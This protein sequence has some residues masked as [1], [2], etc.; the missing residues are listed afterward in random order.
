MCVRAVT[1]SGRTTL[2]FSLLLASISAGASSFTYDF[3]S[4]TASQPLVGQDGWAEIAGLASPTLGAGLGVNPSRVSA[5][6]GSAGGNFAGATRTLGATFTYSP[7]DTAV[8]WEFDGLVSSAENSEVI[9]VG[10][11]G[12]RGSFGQR[13]STTVLVSDLGPFFG[14]RLVTG[15]WYQYQLE[16][17]FSVVGIGSTLRYRDLTAGEGAFITDG[18]IRDISLGMIPIDGKYQFDSVF[19]QQRT[20]GVGTYIDNV[21]IGVV[22]LPP[23]VALLGTGLLFMASRPFRRA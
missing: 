23:A 5:V 19:I 10:L 8:I 7:A 4:L 21:R 14:D 18:S 2:I 13:G 15:H 6:T 9:L 11:A 16:L 1:R 12:N 20:S 3:E 17:D 22:P